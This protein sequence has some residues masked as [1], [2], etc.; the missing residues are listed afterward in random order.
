MVYYWDVG[1]LPSSDILKKHKE[2]NVSETI[3]VFFLRRGMGGTYF[4]ESIRKS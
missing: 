2:Q 1:L 4:I 3:S